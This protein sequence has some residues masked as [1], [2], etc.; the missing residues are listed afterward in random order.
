MIP[1]SNTAR[2]AAVAALVVCA[3]VHARALGAQITQREY[4]ARRDSLAARLD[5]GVVVAFGGRTPVT[6][7][8]TFF[9]LPGFHYLTGFDEPDAA[10][11]MVVRRGHGA[12]TLFLTPINPRTAFY[13]GRRPDSAAVRR[14]L[15]IPGRSF[16]A[17]AGVLDSLAATGLPFYALPDVE[18]ADFAR[19]DSLTRGQLFMR[20]FAAR[21]A[22]AV[23][24]SAQP[25]VDQLRA[26]KSPAE[27]ALLE[28]AA[29]ISSA[30][31]RAAMLVAQ[32]RHE[33]E[34]R[35]ALEN[36]FTRLGAERVAYGSIV[37]AGANGTQ[38]H[39]MKDSAVAR[40]GDVVVMDA[41]GEYQGYAADITRTIPVSGTY[42][43]AQR[44]IYQLVRDAQSV[45]ERNS[46]AGVKEQIAQDSSF[47]VRARGLAALGLVEGADA[48]FDPPWPA[49]CARQPDACK[50]A[51][52]W[53]IHGISHGLGLAV[54]DPAQ[55]YYGDRTYQVGDAFT[56]EPG[57]YISS[58]AL[59]DLPD[60]RRNRAFIAHVRASV[61]RYDNTGVRIEDD[62]VIT[63]T[64]LER[65]STAP[66]EIGEI[67]SLMKQRRSVL[68]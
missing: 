46:R 49:D 47:D 53:M 36:A 22:G 6:D 34:L 4:S 65:I 31:H 32:P 28:K 5:S 25:I 45:A 12:P 60:T 8:G 63:P 2:R 56:I 15:G 67:E 19:A 24:R 21:H 57:I 14:A 61:A 3:G 33:Y 23:V 35:A 1:V 29:E 11:V 20:E 51:Q 64:G 62:Y 37:G 48:T 58:R 38:L 68:P 50:Q 10:L 17:L 41:A 59:A 40:P 42:T 16:A 13:Y 39:Y 26:R 43:P 54:H 9:Q 18:D 7:F 30:G 55:F 66:R 52:L 27:I 44:R